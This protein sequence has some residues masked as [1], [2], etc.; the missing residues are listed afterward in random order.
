[1]EKKQWEDE[2]ISDKAKYPIHFLMDVL[3][4]KMVLHSQRFN[5]MM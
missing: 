4:L 1:M 5:I 2:R 3:D